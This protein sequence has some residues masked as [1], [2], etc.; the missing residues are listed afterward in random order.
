M[1]IIEAILLEP[2]GCLAEFPAQ[3][4]NEIAAQ[5]FGRKNKPSKSGSRS[6]WHLLNLMEAAGNQSVEALELEAVDQAGAYEDV[7]P[8]LTELK[9][10]GIQLFLTS[11]LSNAAITR[12]VAKNGLQEFFS[13]I[14]TRDNAA[15][16]KA[17]P[18]RSAIA[19]A[20]LNP[21]HVMYL[22]DT[23][24]GLK[25]AN[26]LGVISVLMM[27]DPDEARRLTTHE[28]SGGI[29]SLHE[30]PDFIRLVAAENAMIKK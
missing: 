6:Y 10:M 18:L 24:E 11:S 21:E 1:Q 22:T 23:A 16:I 13:A 26:S 30:L 5:C 19:A 12:F 3:P 9:A 14:W 17:A 28:P 25:V 20:L 2:V 15:G 7:I 4:F 8:A 27:N 29:V